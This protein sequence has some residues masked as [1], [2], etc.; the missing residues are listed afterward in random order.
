[1]I[2]IIILL[3][4]LVSCNLHNTDKSLQQEGKDKNG[5]YIPQFRTIGRHG[6]DHLHNSNTEDKE[7]PNAMQLTEGSLNVCLMVT[8]HWWSYNRNYCKITWIKTNSQNLID[9]DAQE[10]KIFQG[11]FKYSYAVAPIKSHDEYSQYVMPLILF[12]SLVEYIQIRSFKLLKNTLVDLD[13]RK[14]AMQNMRNDVANQVEKSIQAQGYKKVYIYGSLYALY[15]NGGKA[16][17]DII[18]THYEN[19]RWS[20]MKAELTTYDEITDKTSTNIILLN[21]QRFNEFLK[22]VT[23]RHPATKIANTNF[24]AP[25]D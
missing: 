3:L 9:P 6:L 14:G 5:I 15:P 8:G 17:L 19:N 7:D 22:E 21:T 11:K 16:L 23:K 25:V 24:K 2:K 12:E 1:M 13:F 18:K 10:S 20:F 4:I